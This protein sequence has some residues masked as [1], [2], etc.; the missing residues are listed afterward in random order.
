MLNEVQCLQTSDSIGKLPS[1][2]HYDWTIQG[3][4]DAYLQLTLWLI[5]P[6]IQKDD[7]IFYEKVYQF[8]DLI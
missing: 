6:G 3:I 7:G 2:Q 5:Q 4:I 1:F 8:T